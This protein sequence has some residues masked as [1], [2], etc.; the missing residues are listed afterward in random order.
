MIIGCSRSVFDT[1]CNFRQHIIFMDRREFRK[2]RVYLPRQPLV[3]QRPWWIAG[4]LLAFIIVLIAAY[5][6]L[7]HKKNF[8]TPD[9]QK[10]ITFEGK[11]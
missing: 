5:G 9:G 2:L 10:K 1:L 4:M 6:Y 8:T 11:R 3:N 7:K